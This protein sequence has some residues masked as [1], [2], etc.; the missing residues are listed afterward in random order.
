[1]VYNGMAW[2]DSDCLDSNVLGCSKCK[3]S[4]MQPGVSQ[5]CTMQKTAEGIEIVFIVKS[6]DSCGSKDVVRQAVSR[7]SVAWV[8]IGM[9][10][11]WGRAE[12]HCIH[13]AH[14]GWVPVLV[15]DIYKI[16]MLQNHSDHVL[17]YTQ[18]HIIILKIHWPMQSTAMFTNLQIKQFKQ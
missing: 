6:G 12:T 17:N 2:N 7:W 5:G 3:T 8:G 16:I 10:E 4:I 11:W 14:Q 13:D 18:I 1:M 15:T 9:G